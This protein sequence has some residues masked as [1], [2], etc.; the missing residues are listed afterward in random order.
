MNGL[1]D[2]LL[3]LDPWLIQPFRWLDAPMPAF[4]LGL[5][6]LSLVCVFLG[7]IASLGVLRLNRKV[8]GGY[9]KDM[10]HHHELSITAA[11]T[12]SKENFKAVNRQAHDAFGKY[13]FSQAA[14]FTSSIWPV[15]FALAWLDMRFQG[16]LIKLPLVDFEA[17]YVFFFLPL[18]ILA[19]FLYSRTIG[20][21]PWYL[22]VRAAAIL[23]LGGEAGRSA[24]GGEGGREGD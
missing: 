8:F 2:L 14:V 11:K 16:V 7:D 6:A 15:P 1:R 21:I 3:V 17:N 5:F 24:S 10:V 22:R 13:F 4:L 12:G 23:D 18:Y 9:I 19:R 20:R